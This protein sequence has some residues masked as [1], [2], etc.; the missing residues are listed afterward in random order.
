MP[1]E[2]NT[3]CAV[4]LRDDQDRAAGTCRNPVEHVVLWRFVGSTERLGLCADHEVVYR[5]HPRLIWSQ[6]LVRRIPA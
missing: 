6:P 4:I 5:E 2:P 3:G 1:L